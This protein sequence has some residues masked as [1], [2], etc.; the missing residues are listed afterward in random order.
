MFLEVLIKPSD[1]G[2]PGWLLRIVVGFLEERILI[3]LY[4]G[5]KSGVKEMPGGGPQETILR[6]F[7]IPGF[8]Q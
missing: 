7:F 4:K 6:M 5:E 2:V 8:D 3:V 1:M